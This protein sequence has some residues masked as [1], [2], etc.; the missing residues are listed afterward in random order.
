MITSLRLPIASKR[1]VYIKRQ[2]QGRVD[3]AMTLVLQL[4][5]KTMESLRNEM[6][7]YSRATLFVCIDFND[8]YDAS[9]IAAL[10]LMPG[11]NRQL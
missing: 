6:Q 10:T 2:H 3:A 5:L 7:S 1:P 11:V 8:S 4:S 9:I